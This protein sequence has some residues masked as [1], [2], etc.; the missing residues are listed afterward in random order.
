MRA[1]PVVGPSWIEKM[2]ST[3]FLGTLDD[4][5]VDGGAELAVA[6]IDLD[7]ALD[8]GLHLRARE[9]HARLQLHFLLEVLGR[10][11]AVTLVV[12]LVD[13]RALDDV[14]DERGLRRVPVQ[15]HVRKQP[16]SE[17]RLQGA[18]GGGRR[19][20]IAFAK[21]DIGEH[22]RGLDA[23][24]SLDHDMQDGRRGR[25]SGG[26]RRCSGCRRRSA[27]PRRHLRRD[28]AVVKRAGEQQDDRSRARHS[29]EQGFHAHPL[30][31]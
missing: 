28:R 16:R 14:D 10:D 3:R 4:L 29:G 12:D 1:T 8:V 20:R 6:A 5:R 18:V 2:R 24:R 25:R 21:G 30:V 27:E 7:D 26:G 31:S 13:D 11:L 19:I 22:R 17:Q 23:L 15:P 9:H